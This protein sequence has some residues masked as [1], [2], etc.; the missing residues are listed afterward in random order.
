MTNF[1]NAAINARATA[2]ADARLALED[3]NT[4]VSAAAA[5][6]DGISQRIAALEADRTSILADRRSG[7]HDD[8]AHGARLAII[9]VDVDEL[10]VMLAEAEAP[11]APLRNTADNARH[12]VSLAEQT[13][14]TEREDEILRLTI[15]RADQL[16]ALLLQAVKD[17]EAHKPRKLT[18]RNLW[19]PDPAVA[20]ALHR[21]HLTRI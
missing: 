4:A 16:S 12:R 2:L 3:A 21:L 11:V 14:V 20:D 7:H 13:L 19:S 18:S 5:G 8:E 6:L 9:A 1:A 17:I 15:E 10:R